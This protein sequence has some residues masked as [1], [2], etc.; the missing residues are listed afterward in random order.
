[1]LPV[2]PLIETDYLPDYAPSV[3]VVEWIEEDPLNELEE[4]F[5]LQEEQ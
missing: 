2:T 4:Y 3:Y 5:I 1:M